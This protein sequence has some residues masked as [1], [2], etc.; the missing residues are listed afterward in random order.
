MATSGDI[1]KSALRKLG[2][3]S[4]GEGPSSDELA[5]GLTS[6][7]EMIESF[8]NESL[9]IFGDNEETFPFVGSQQIYTMG[10]GGDFDTARPVK[11]NRARLKVNSSSPAFELPI[12]I[13]N[14]DEWAQITNKLTESTQPESI[15]VSYENPLA[16]IYVYNVPSTTNSIILNSMKVV[17]SF[18]SAAIAINM[19]AGYNRLLAYNLAMELAPEYGMEPSPTIQRIA[20][21]SK[22][23]VMRLNTEYPIST[24]DIS[25]LVGESTFNWLSGE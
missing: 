23:N 16:K 4:S 19:P 21:E 8:S 22:A 24:S 3:I 18:S 15:Y 10:T 11:I 7:N 13:L 14:L 9:F 1:I 25:I 17:Q 6:L 2:V 20:A 12:S 5:D